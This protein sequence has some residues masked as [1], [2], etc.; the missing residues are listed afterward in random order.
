MKVEHEDL[1]EAEIELLH[2]PII[3]KISKEKQKYDDSKLLFRMLKAAQRT[4]YRGRG[5]RRSL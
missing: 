4:A 2:H 1:V 3:E 5:A